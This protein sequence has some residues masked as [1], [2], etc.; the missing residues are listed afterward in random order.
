MAT[1]PK[2]EPALLLGFAPC[3]MKCGNQTARVRVNVGKHPY[4]YCNG[5]GDNHPTRSHPH[6][7]R[8]VD[9]MTSITEAGAAWLEA[10]NFQA[11]PGV[12]SVPTAAAPAAAP[13]A[14]TPNPPPA[15]PAAA[16]RA[17]SWLERL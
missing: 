15:A 17:L 3:H 12:A 4:L 2:K 1:A 10:N 13:A 14:P 11:P 6:A 7:Q 9:Q 16:P 5:C 8:L